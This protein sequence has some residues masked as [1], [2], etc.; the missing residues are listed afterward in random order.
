MVGLPK[1]VVGKEAYMHRFTSACCAVAL[2]FISLS[3]FAI[4]IPA[5]ETTPDA[6]SIQPA[7]A[8]TDEGEVPDVTEANAPSSPVKAAA[9]P[10]KESAVQLKLNEDYFGIQYKNFRLSF[11]S[12]GRVGMT[13]N[14]DGGS[15]KEADVVSHG[16]RLE[17]TPYVELDLYAEYLLDDITFKTVIT[18]A[19][20]NLENM[21]HYSGQPGVQL[22]VRN[23]FVEAGDIYH[24][25]AYIWVGSRMYRGDDIYLLDYW[26]MDNL[27]TYGGGL[28]WRKY[29]LEIAFHVGVNRLNNDYQYQEVDVPGRGYGVE[30]I[31]TL[32]R[33]RTILSLGFTHQFP[34][35]LGDLGVK[36]KLYGEFHYLP[37]GEY[38][39]TD[40]TI[41][42]LPADNGFLIGAELGTWG[43]CKN[44][45]LNL[46]FKYGRNLAAYNELAVPYGTNLD[47][48]TSG[49]NE[50]LF[51]FS[52]NY[53][54]EYF[55]ILIGGYVKRW[56]D[57][58][59]EEY[60][61]FDH[62]E[63]ILVA[64]P[65]AFIGKYFRV[66]FET[67]YQRRESPGTADL[68]GTNSVPAVFKFSPMISLATGK[69][70]LSRPEIRLLYTMA[71]LNEGARYL[72][73]FGDDRRSNSI[74]HF[75][76][77]GVEWWFNA[78]GY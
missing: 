44:G 42:A 63:F 71:Y 8:E 14:F 16:T 51:G 27:N 34:K 47:K 19:L 43:F 1:P 55:S 39:R 54:H 46:F 40:Q 35:I 67:S 3:A 13:T 70:S 9:A 53:E 25:G 28:G 2:F 72:Y 69:G 50:L 61:P 68:I 21:F 30:T 77:F 12:Y 52:G 24:T 66:G 26:A 4:E 20:L 31:T 73:P 62:A 5:D 17:E 74:Q 7:D 57:A 18:L 23:L 59:P 6:D 22:A 15:G 41:E 36:Y 32:D 45:F 76:G 11:G 60:D 65:M 29:N 49:A 48:T 56:L 38:H 37:S 64:R 10:V 33:Q 78:Y 75:L 58:L